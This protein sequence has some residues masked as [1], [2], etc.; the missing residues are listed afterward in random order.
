MAR[1]DSKQIKQWE[2]QGHSPLKTN[3]LHG[4]VRIAYF[5]FRADR[6]A[7]AL[8]VAQNDDVRL[9]Q[10]PAGA[11]LIGGEFKHG[12]FGASVTLDIGLRALDGSGYLD[13]LNTVA[14]DPDALATNLDIA[15]AGFKDVFEETP[16]ILY[17]TEKEL[18]V[19]ALFEGA[20]P[21]DNIELAGYVFYVVD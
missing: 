12:A 14:D 15:A 8:V 21:A 16:Y 6:D 3:E 18:E 5:Q 9:C 13:K 20:N 11:R 4:R 17:E 19:Y 7:A 2:A 10:L 1:H